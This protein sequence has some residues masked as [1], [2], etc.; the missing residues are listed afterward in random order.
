MESLNQWAGE[1]GYRIEPY[2][3]DLIESL[4]VLARQRL[5]H[6]EDYIFVGNVMNWRPPDVPHRRLSQSE[7][8]CV[9]GA[10]RSSAKP[11][12]WTRTV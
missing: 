9:T 12:G 11:R 10:T 4:A 8:S 7:R 2:G 6:W 1:E 3:L 5:R